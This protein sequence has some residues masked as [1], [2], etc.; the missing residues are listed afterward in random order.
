MAVKNDDSSNNSTPQ[1]QNRD[2]EHESL[3]QKAHKRVQSAAKD[4]IIYDVIVIG[5]GI[6]GVTAALMLQKAGKKCF[7]AEA[8]RLGFG[9]TGGTSAH[10]NTFADTTY[11]EAESAFGEA[12]ARLFAEAVNEGFD[13]IRQNVSE[14]GINCD[15]EEKSGFLYAQTEDEVKQLADICTG[16]RKV[17]VEVAYAETVLTPIEYKKALIF[18][19][20]AQ[21]HPLKYLD[22]LAAAFIG[23]GGIIA[24]GA[25][26]RDLQTTDDI[27]TAS[28]DEI[29]VKGKNVI[30]ATHIPPGVNV[31]SF[32]CAPNRSYVLAATLKSGNYPD[33]LIYDM[34]EPYHYFRT[35]KIGGQ[36][37]LLVGGN[38]HKTGHDESEKAFSALEN[39][40]RK[41]YDVDEIPFKWSSQ[42]YVPVDGLP[43]IGHMTGMSEG[44][45]CATGYNGNGMMLGSIAA[46]I[47]ADLITTGDSRFKELF[48]PSR[49]KPIAGFN[50][51]VKENADVVYQFVASR[52]TGHKVDFIKRVRKGTGKIVEFED[53]KLA[54]YH[55]EE[56][57]LHVLS[58][59]CT[60][61]HCIVN[62]NSEEKTW[63]CPCHGARYDID[64]NVL[65]GPATENLRK[66][67]FPGDESV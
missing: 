45:Y 53:R 22:A 6:T 13:I 10:I 37:Y 56:G 16:T 29:S 60:H 32:R 49:I 11:K 24:E 21:F 8:H 40:I 2:G 50:E 47:L 52:F 9:T 39:Y 48:S 64:G 55:D 20:Q 54:V 62:W 35:H 26:I 42:Y 61:A 59:V 38:D 25:C 36:K 15:F 58:P 33:C 7:L 66:I 5:G 63:D 67:E 44:I 30:Y 19:G 57:A 41:H 17:G 43:Y 18:N 28:G 3:W 4:D 14:L 12:G 1:H 27:H 51:F 23:L 46:K 34:Q 31:F 65:N